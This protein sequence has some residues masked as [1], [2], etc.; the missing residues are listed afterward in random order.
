MKSLESHTLYPRGSEWGKWD[1]HVHTPASIINS[2]G[3][4]HD[5]AWEKYIT[6]LEA[7]P[8]EF[9]VLG[10]ND[11][12]F[13][14]GYERLLKEKEENGRLLNIDL[15]LP[16]IEFRIDQLTGI[17]FSK[18]NN[19]DMH[20]I[21]SNELSTE[22]IRAQFLNR[23]SADFN[24]SKDGAFDWNGAIT[25]QSLEELGANIRESTP[26]DN[27]NDLP[28]N[29]ILGFN[30]IAL[31]F[32]KLKDLLS[33][34]TYLKGKY[35]TCIGKAEWDQ[36]KWSGA[37]IAAKKSLINYADIIFTASPSVEK[38][39]KAKETL[40]KQ[41]VNHLL[42]DCSDAHSFST[43]SIK[44]R[45]G[46]CHTW[47]KAEPSFDG[48]KQILYEPETRIY[49]GSDHPDQKLDYEVIDRIEI[50]NDHI[51]NNVIYFNPSLNTIVGGRSSGKSTLV[52]CIANKVAPSALE[53]GKPDDHIQKISDTM[54]II[55]KDG[56]ED[57]SRS[58]DY[59]YQGHMYHRAKKEDGI[60]NIIKSILFQSNTQLYEDSENRI[61]HL[62]Q[63]NA[64]SLSRMFSR[65]KFI[66]NKRE[67]IQSIGNKKDILEQVTKLNDLISGSNTAS[68]SAEEFQEHEG[69]QNRL[70][71]LQ[72]RLENCHK[73]IAEINNLTIDNI[74]SFH[75]FLPN[76]NFV[77]QNI[78][79]L[80]NNKLDE[81]KRIA[82]T[83]IE[84]FKVEAIASLDLTKE[85]LNSQIVAIAE[86]AKFK[87]IEKYL[88]D[89]ITLK[90]LISKR[91]G[92]LSK[93][94]QIRSLELEIESAS[95]EVRKLYYVVV[96]NWKDIN[97]EATELTNRIKVSL[98]P[99]L[100]I[101]LKPKFNVSEFKEFFIKY[102]NQQ[103][104]RAQGYSVLNCDSYKDL[105]KGFKEVRTLLKAKTIRLKS[106]FTE[107]SFMSEFFTTNWFKI[108]YDV[109]YESDSYAEMSQGKKAFVVLKLS[110]E[111]SDR[112]CPII[113]DQPE[114]DLDNRA[115]Y[116]ELVTYIKEK[117]SQRQIILVTHNA[118][119]VVN[120]DSEQIIVANQH[121]SK[122][123]NKDN[124]KFEYKFGSIESN[125]YSRTNGSSILESK[126]I[127]EHVCEI[128]EG[129][130]TAFKLREQKYN[131]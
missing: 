16:V 128:L 106:N 22:C 10:I 80:F 107:E 90:P 51:V 77:D 60:E 104:E 57:D 40:I 20:V 25:F 96:H 2:F 42:L 35:L 115:I 53:D 37:R 86:N 5:E 36:F 118:N 34:S 113:I 78:K 102:V 56:K 6:D 62:T 123:P 126:T 95:Q 18:N 33:S 43:A 70:K 59:F 50:E 31:S 94:G 13:L 9:K 130:N 26:L 105:F 66:G 119:V 63:I 15:L 61:A 19:I 120:A 124:K 92:E 101:I 122:T 131:F 45:I 48:L 87:Q 110:L 76:D 85:T 52:Q 23:L 114:D 116:T 73:V 68:Y 103:T 109:S 72:L 84:A 117:K 100:E 74:L 41:G 21:F 65:I 29:R 30:N 83:Q 7:L 129:G 32:D 27:R 121:G 108:N 89:E 49:I 39:N 1:L 71:E 12:W 88:K 28:S 69:N 127:K 46:N 44:D 11:Y 67:H 98:N 79:S 4:D 14:D 99:G 125:D 75:E 38:Y 82:V 55:W 91:E 17:D 54:K 111:C 112:K 97:N 8:P 93:L 58:V 3:G 64:G 24:L 81:I 47:I